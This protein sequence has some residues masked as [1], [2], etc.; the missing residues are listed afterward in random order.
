LSNQQND[1][2]KQLAK[3]L[4]ILSR[5]E[6]ILTDLYYI[7]SEI[8]DVLK[9]RKKPGEVTEALKALDVM[10][11]LELPDHLRK[12][13]MALARLGEARAQDVAEVTGRER[14]VESSYLNQLAR[15]GYVRK[16]RKRKEV[17]FRLAS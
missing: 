1:V 11:L 9:G 10:T 3:I 12:T 7:E 4:E 16:V 14:A 6:E 2:R 17:W 13:A 8:R 15:L 5:I